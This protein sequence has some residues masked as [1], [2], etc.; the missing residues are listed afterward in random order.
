[1]K[2]SIKN[3]IAI[4][5]VSALLVAGVMGAGCTQD[6]GSASSQSPGDQATPA[7]T[8]QVAADGTGQHTPSYGTDSA[9]STRQH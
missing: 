3:T 5:I 1:M 7:I 2:K 9:G 8:H 4:L 6:N